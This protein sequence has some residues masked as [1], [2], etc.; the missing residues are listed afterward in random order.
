MYL[1]FGNN[2]NNVWEIKNNSEDRITAIYRGRLSS[3]SGTIDDVVIEERNYRLWKVFTNHND[4]TTHMP[5]AFPLIYHMYTNGFEIPTK[6][7][8]SKYVFER[9]S[10]T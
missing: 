4:G 8:D 9:I 1:R 2:P 5:D 7:R 3:V 6:I 10:T